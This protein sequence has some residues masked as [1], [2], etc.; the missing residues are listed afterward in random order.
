M[1]RFINSPSNVIYS[2]IKITICDPEN[3]YIEGIDMYNQSIRLAYSFYHSPYI[4]VP[5]IGESWIVKKIDNNWNLYAR[6]ETE[7]QI[8]P[9]KDLSPGDV[10]IESSNI[11]H[12]NAEEEILI[13][14]NKAAPSL[15]NLNDNTLPG[16]AL[17]GSGTLNQF[18]AGTLIYTNK[19]ISPLVSGLSTADLLDG[20][21]EKLIVPCTEDRMIWSFRY[22]ETNSHWEFIGGAPHVHFTPGTITNTGTDWVGT[23]PTITIPYDGTYILSGGAE[24]RSDA[25]NTGFNLGL[26]INGSAPIA[27]L[28]AYA[29]EQ[30]KAVSVNTT[31]KVPF[32]KNDVLVVQYRKDPDYAPAGTASFFNKWIR[33][34]PVTVTT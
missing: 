10:R 1:S 18:S 16:T 31:Y 11:L 4:Q 20:Q 22:E 17:F 24:A 25:N 6:F 2:R 9:I 3:G 28:E 27:T 26:S 8:I 32:N 13:D 33:I 5:Q 29:P 30:N 23:A 19:I 15:R 34:E 21:E 7:N 12:I 14:F